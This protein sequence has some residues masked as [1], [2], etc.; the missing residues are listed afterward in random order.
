MGDRW[1]RFRDEAWIFNWTKG[2]DLQR[3]IQAASAKH[4]G[5]DI[6][7]NPFVSKDMQKGETS[8]I[9]CVLLSVFGTLVGLFL[10]FQLVLYV[11]FCITGH[12]DW[13]WSLPYLLRL[14]RVDCRRRDNSEGPVGGTRSHGTASKEE[15][16][17]KGQWDHSGTKGGGGTVWAHV[18]PGEEG[19]APVPCRRG[20]FFT[21]R[22][23]SSYFRSI[24]A[25]MSSNP[26][27]GDN[28][29]ARGG[30]ISPLPAAV[31]L[32]DPHD[33]SVQ[34]AQDPTLPP[35]STRSNWRPTSIISGRGNVQRRP[36]D[37]AML[38]PAPSTNGGDVV[39][40]HCEN[41]GYESDASLA[42][43]HTDE[44]EGATTDPAEPSAEGATD[45]APNDVLSDDSFTS[46]SS[47]S[48]TS[49]SRS[50][51]QSLATGRRNSSTRSAKSK[52][53]LSHRKRVS[54]EAA[55][56]K[57]VRFKTNS[58]SNSNASETKVDVCGT[59]STSSSDEVDKDKSQT[60]SNGIKVSGSTNDL[61]KI[62][63]LS[64]GNSDGRGQVA[65]GQLDKDAVQS[66]QNIVAC[67]SNGSNGKKINLDTGGPKNDI[68]G[69]R[70]TGRH[71][72]EVSE[73]TSDGNYPDSNSS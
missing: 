7:I 22:S 61:N 29:V 36:A 32:V 35:S 16:T 5:S 54:S 63:S 72:P 21:A 20:F 11:R 12:H 40:F 8:L 68:I 2:N 48:L 46:I 3:A 30:S 17:E 27:A 56:S 43:T 65:K 28:G 59:R 73:S 55:D 47:L 4:Q 64:R 37:Q 60:I 70:E 18:Y 9:E 39:M 53:S 6:D 42:F 71:N 51:C 45:S 26:T 31:F 69:E 49:L 19:A 13:K 41:P 57:R 33:P 24:A 67:V 14:R 62:D 10:V 38:P 44:D 15:E 66:E 23:L 58:R 34:A 25:S 52:A 50:R 1:L